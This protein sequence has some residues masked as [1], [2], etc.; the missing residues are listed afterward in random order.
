MAHG[1]KGNLFLASGPPSCWV[2]GDAT[3]PLGLTLKENP[4]KEI[5]QGI[6]KKKNVTK[7]TLM[8]N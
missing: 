8:P 4:I 3:F 1:Q 5:F 2:S 6:S 7:E